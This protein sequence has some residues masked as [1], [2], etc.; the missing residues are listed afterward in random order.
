MV[1]CTPR[2]DLPQLL[3]AIRAVTG[4][5]LLIG[6]TSSGELVQGA[7]MGFG[8]GV[9]VLALTADLTASQRHRPAISAMTWTAPPRISPGPA[10]PR[11]ALSHAG[12][13]VLADALLGDMQ[14]VV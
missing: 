8:A 1:F 7:Y 3:A 11:P 10:G 2:Y 5:T 6:A 9:A 13:L 12:V 4:A 14:M